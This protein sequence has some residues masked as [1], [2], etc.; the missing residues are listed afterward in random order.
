MDNA[1]NN[2]NTKF[3]GGVHAH[4]PTMSFEE[5]KELPVG[6]IAAEDCALFLWTTFPYI[7]KQ[8]E[9]FSAWGFEY[10]FHGVRKLIKQLY[11]IVEPLGGIINCHDSSMNFT[12]MGF[13]HLMWQGELFQVKFMHNGGENFPSDFLRAECTGRNLGVPTELLVYQN[14]P[15]WTFEHATALALVH[16]IFPRPNDI[17]FPLEFI[18]KIW[19]ITDAFP[20]EKSKFIPYWENT[21]IV[22]DN[23]NVKCSYYEYKDVL[24]KKHLLLM[25]SNLST[26][27]IHDAHFTYGSRKITFL[28]GTASWKKEAVDFE[29]YTYFIALADEKE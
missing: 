28:N 5:I 26:N 6:K 2:L 12:A 3:G 19:K 13:S 24:G 15:I 20:M 16:G 11:S 10:P 8:L 9:V 17:G 25:A 27:E 29:K 22:C 4:Y 23:E 21:E 1:R 18:S 14:R 7:D